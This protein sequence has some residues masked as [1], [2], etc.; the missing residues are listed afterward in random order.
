LLNFE[1]ENGIVEE[2]VSLLMNLGNI[3][4]TDLLKNYHDQFIKSLSTKIICFNIS[5]D[6]ISGEIKRAII[7]TFF[8]I[9]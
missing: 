3:S 8:L 7:D 1:V 5:N 4:P 2:A 6:I 9:I